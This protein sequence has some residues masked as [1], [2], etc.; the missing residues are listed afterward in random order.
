M[1]EGRRKIWLSRYLPSKTYRF[2]VDQFCLL[3]LSVYCIWTILLLLFFR[4]LNFFAYFQGGGASPTENVKKD[5]TPRSYASAAYAPRS[6]IAWVAANKFSCTSILTL[7][8]V[9]SSNLKSLYLLFYYKWN[10]AEAIS[11]MI[12]TLLVLFDLLRFPGVFREDIMTFPQFITSNG[13]FCTGGHVVTC[14]K[15]L[16]EAMHY[17]KVTISSLRCPLH[18]YYIPYIS[19]PITTCQSEL[20]KMLKFYL[21]MAHINSWTRST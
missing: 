15:Y 8:I 7:M 20:L 9:K 12:R 2:W 11:F 4:F 6:C 21:V 1:T 5:T 13:I 10:R 3:H 17:G 19:F 14:T 18:V 16:L